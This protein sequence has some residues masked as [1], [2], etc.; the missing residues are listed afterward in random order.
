MSWWLIKHLELWYMYNPCSARVHIHSETRVDIN[1]YIYIFIYIYQSSWETMVSSLPTW[2][3]HTLCHTWTVS[4]LSSSAAIE[5]GLALLSFRVFL[6]TTLIMC[7]ILFLHM[8]IIL[9]NHHVARV[10]FSMGIAL[11]GCVLNAS[12]VRMLVVY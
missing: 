1:I 5:E 10:C 9:G 12:Y 11:D 2:R 8:T 7:I 4:S 3:S 6:N